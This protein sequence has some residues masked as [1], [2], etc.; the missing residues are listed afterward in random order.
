LILSPAEMEQFIN[1]AAALIAGADETF[2]AC[3]PA[4]P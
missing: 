3:P 4:G 1:E 2:G